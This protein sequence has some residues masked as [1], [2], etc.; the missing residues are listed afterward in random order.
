MEMEH[1]IKR[2]L[3]GKFVH[4]YK[5]ILKGTALFV[6]GDTNDASRFEGICA[7]LKKYFFIETLILTDTK[8]YERYAELSLKQCQVL[9][10]KRKEE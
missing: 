8:T 10:Y 3:D 6:L 5:I 9:Q 1:H 4:P 7:A 2:Y